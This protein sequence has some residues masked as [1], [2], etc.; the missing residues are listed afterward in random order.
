M[1]CYVRDM[2]GGASLACAWGVI[3]ACLESGLRVMGRELRAALA[4]L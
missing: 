2:L 3:V 1:L 4:E